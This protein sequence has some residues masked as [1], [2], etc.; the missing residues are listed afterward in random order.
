MVSLPIVKTAVLE[1]P[2]TSPGMAA[3]LAWIALNAAD[4]LIT[5]YS[6]GV[7]ASEGNPLLTSVQHFLGA[8]PMLLVKMAGAVLVGALV[9][10]WGKRHVLRAMVWGML[11]VV[12]YNLVVVGYLLG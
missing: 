10:R 7:G 2:R 1:R 5:W 9:W 12:A 4:A 11:I 3:L 8:G 6:F